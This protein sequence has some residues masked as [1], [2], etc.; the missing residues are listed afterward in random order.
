MEKGKNTTSF[1]DY[2]LRSMSKPP[3]NVN[4]RTFFSFPLRSA[5][6]Y[7]NEK[8]N[9]WWGPFRMMMPRWRLNFRD[10]FAFICEISSFFS[11]S[12]RKWN[13]ID[14][15][16]SI[17]AIVLWCCLCLAVSVFIG[18][19][20]KCCYVFAPK[21]FSWLTDLINDV[22]AFILAFTPRLEARQ[23]VLPPAVALH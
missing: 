12:S 6:V 14:R 10:S 2:R 21:T 15:L 7:G 18:L 1:Y 22:I 17:K 11:I 8:I 23:I 5:H 20:E 9:K 4:N 19:I 13:Q 3:M 16:T